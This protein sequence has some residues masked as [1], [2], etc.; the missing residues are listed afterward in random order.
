MTACKERMLSTVYDI[1][2]LELSLPV[3][4]HHNH[5]S[6]D[7]KQSVHLILPAKNYHLKQQIANQKFFPSLCQQLLQYILRKQKASKWFF[8]TK[9]PFQ[10]SLKLVLMQEIPL[11]SFRSTLILWNGVFGNIFL[12]EF[13]VTSLTNSLFNECCII[14][15]PSKQN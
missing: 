4:I 12:C 2:K 1:N 14:S 9:S 15:C 5:L 8:L 7:T 11:S 6:L 3:Y 10:C 13:T